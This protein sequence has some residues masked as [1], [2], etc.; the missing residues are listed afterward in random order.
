MNYRPLAMPTASE[1]IAIQRPLTPIFV[2][3]VYYKTKCGMWD[4][5]ISMKS[6]EINL[7]LKAKP[8]FSESK[9]HLLS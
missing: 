2:V 8:H 4:L 9:F 3:F 6:R 7:R 1:A 5:Y